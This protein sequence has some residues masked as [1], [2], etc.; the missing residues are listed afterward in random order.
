M[1]ALGKC[2][3]ENMLQHLVVVRSALERNF[4]WILEAERPQIVKPEDM[5]RMGHGCTTLRQYCADFR[6]VLVD[7]KV[8]GA[9]G[10][11]F[12][13]TKKSKGGVF[14]PLRA[15]HTMFF[16]RSLF[17]LVCVYFVFL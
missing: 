11:I 15:R 12:R 6:A 10:K 14:L 16:F 5:I 7:G 2:V 3:F 1:I 4:M 13:T 8:P 9:T 17:S